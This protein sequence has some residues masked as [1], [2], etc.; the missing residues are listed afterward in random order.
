MKITFAVAI[1][2]LFLIIV[3]SWPLSLHLNTLIV[4]DV[5]GLLITW[6]LN[7]NI[8]SFG[9]GLNG[10]LN[11]FDAN[12]FYPYRNTLA[13]SDTMLGQ[14]LLIWPFMFIFKQP[15]LAYNLVLIIGF[16]L[17]GMSVFHIVYF[18]TRSKFFPSITAAL[19][20]NMSTLHF[21]YM[22]HLQ[23]FT[24]WPVVYTF[25]FLLRKRYL[26]F[27]ICFVISGLTTALFI[28]FLAFV[29]SV[30]FLQGLI[31]KKRTFFWSCG[32]L[33][34]LFIF[35]Y[36]YWLV[37]KQFN[38]SRP[39]TDAIHFSLQFPDI[40]TIGSQS[41]FTTL[42]K[43]IHA[44]TPAYPGLVFVF[45][46][47]A[48]IYD[49]LKHRSIVRLNSYMKLL[50]VLAVISFILALGPALHLQSH[51]V[52]IGP[53][54]AFPLPYFFL[55]YLVPGFSGFRTPSRWIILSFFTLLIAI[56]YYFSKRITWKVTVLALFLLLLEFK[57][58]VFISV[59]SVKNFPPEQIWLR[60]NYKNEPIIQ[61]PIYRWDDQPGLE[62]ETLREYYSTIHWHPMYNGYSGFSP[63]EWENDVRWLQSNFP[64]N[65]AI[66]FLTHKK[67]KLVLV[68]ISWEDRMRQYSQL[69]QVA[70][71]PK[72]LIYAL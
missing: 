39:I 7:W 43:P 50:L 21:N 3:V 22:A 5:D 29:I 14:S 15:L 66:N 61:F 56:V 41:R 26:L 59:P 4:D 28:Y 42:F 58:P 2:F 19:I 24:F 12:I 16:V 8:H 55:Y 64:S 52:H 65:D 62:I 27:L 68:P 25:Y 13:Y 33:L 51:T 72:T 36:P 11:L 10:L 17:T 70:V 31:D 9:L 23:L 48:F 34:I 57:P 1:F 45:L 30:L 60:D 67:I 69:K 71:F 46:L 53:L 20:F 40:L 37:S 38:Y 32:A 63:K 49:R 6:I 54:Q 47:G 35:L 44:G 18:L